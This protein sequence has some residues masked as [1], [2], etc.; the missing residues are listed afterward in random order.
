[1]V[2]PKGPQVYVI[3]DSDSEDNGEKLSSKTATASSSSLSD[4]ERKPAAKN[5]AATATSQQKIIPPAV[6]QKQ[7]RCISL[8]DD[9]DSS[10]EDVTTNSTTAASHKNSSSSRKRSHDSE[11]VINVDSDRILAERIAKK[12]GESSQEVME[13]RWEMIQTLYATL[14]SLQGNSS[15]SAERTIYPS[16]ILEKSSPLKNGIKFQ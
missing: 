9:D 1:M 2:L 11:N 7:S 16:F 5:T 8:L 10:V 12:E 14:L 6:Q 3:D 13:K 4:D 15:L